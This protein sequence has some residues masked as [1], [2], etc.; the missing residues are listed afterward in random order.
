MAISA[1][2]Q[3]VTF[4]L[5]QYYSNHAAL[6]IDT[7]ACKSRPFIVSNR[8][9][10]IF[11]HSISI[12][13][14]CMCLV[15]LIM[16][17]SSQIFVILCICFYVGAAEDLI[18]GNGVC[19]TAVK[20]FA[21]KNV[22]FERCTMMKAVADIF[23]MDCIVLYAE[24]FQAYDE[25]QNARDKSAKNENTLCGQEVAE[26]DHF[27]IL[28]THF[29]SSK[30]IWN[31][32]RCSSEWA[33]DKLKPIATNKIDDIIFFPSCRLLQLQSRDHSAEQQYYRNMYEEE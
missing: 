30:N 14:L 13:I 3:R 19:V 26:E 9:D 12:F 29:I 16:S 7:I 22:E 15:V 20:K 18:G 4:F 23:C 28:S 21:E 27:D 32:A 17:R 5:C 2:H 31:R 1:T 10:L 11:K 8:F 33:N 6:G 25:L 24:Q